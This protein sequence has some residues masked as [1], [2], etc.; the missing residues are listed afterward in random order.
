MHRGHA[1]ISGFFLTLILTLAGCTGDL[2]QYVDEDKP[3]VLTI[4]SNTAAT[5]TYSVQNRTVSFSV[6][7]RIDRSGKY[8]LLHGSSC[9]TGKAP[10]GIA[11]AGT[12]TAQSDVTTNLSVSL[13][14]IASY[15]NTVI[16]CTSDTADYQKA[17]A[18]V[19]FS[20]A[21]T[22]LANQN[23][24]TGHGLS[25][26]SGQS[27]EFVFMQSNWTTGSVNRGGTAANN[28]VNNP[29]HHGVFVDPNDSYRMKYFLVDRDNNRVLVFHT[30]P[31][32]SNAGADVVIGQSSFANTGANAG[33]SVSATGLD[34]PSHVAVSSSGRLYI[35]DRGNHRVLG[36]NAIPTTNGGT[37]DFV[38]GQPNMSSNIANNGGLGSQAQRLNDPTSAYIY[39]GRFYVVDRGNNRVLQ[40]GSVPTGTAPT[41][42]MAIGQPDTLTV[43][44]G[45]DYSTTG[46][47]LSGP[48]YAL[49]HETR[50][51]IS[52]G[53]NHRVLVFNSVPSAADTRP[54]FVVGHSG[55][56]FSLANCGLPVSSQCFDGPRALMAQGNKLAVADRNNHRVLFLDLPITANYAAA[57]Q[58]LGQSSMTTN[59][60]AT[61]QAGLNNP[62][63]LLFDNGY[64]WISDSTNNRVVVRQLP[65]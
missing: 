43:A 52:D 51:Y 39:G 22:Y 40:F 34:L 55:A 9:D 3:L 53:G 37:A 38:I 14:D 16:V 36:F 4:V 28:A 64:I 60:A 45:T 62:R 10:S 2:Q 30:A 20:A 41:A 26:T 12:M 15:G 17:S 58:V 57:Q 31:A 56:A 11:N 44:G 29:Y 23:E 32:D 48:Y 24:A 8:R 5:P 33:A 21:L 27:G 49:F 63:S 18:T 42:T 25:F 47:F 35:C 59:A 1:A 46:S 7:F 6:T 19:S 50:F 61:T 65:Y 13:D 54:N